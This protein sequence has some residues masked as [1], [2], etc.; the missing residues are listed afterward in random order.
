MMT[1]F[2]RFTLH[3]QQIALPQAWGDQT[4]PRTFERRALNFWP[5]LSSQ[6]L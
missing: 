2:E 3:S 5:V 1:R 4:V 6:L